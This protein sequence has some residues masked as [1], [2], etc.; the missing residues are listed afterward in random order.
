MT[1]DLQKVNFHKKR[2]SSAGQSSG[3][4]K[5]KPDLP[6]LSPK[7]ST[8]EPTDELDIFLRQTSMEIVAN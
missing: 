3:A 4:G 7:P 8:A 1:R 2:E 5:S 6:T